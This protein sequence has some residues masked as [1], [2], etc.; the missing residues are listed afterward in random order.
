M[1]IET[2][3]NTEKFIQGIVAQDLLVAEAAIQGIDEPIRS[4]I[5]ARR[6][7]LASLERELMAAAGREYVDVFDHYSPTPEIDDFINLWCDLVKKSHTSANFYLIQI[8]VI[9]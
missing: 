6:K 5:D 1:H 8:T 4:T 7:L 3:N 2:N 9:G